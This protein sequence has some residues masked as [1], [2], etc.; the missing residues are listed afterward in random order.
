M[1]D[2]PAGSYPAAVVADGAVHYW[3][4]DEVEGSLVAVDN[5]GA[6]NGNISG[7]VTLGVPGALLSGNASMVFDGISGRIVTPNVINLRPPYTIEAWVRVFEQGGHAFFSTL[8]PDE[9]ED[10]IYV[11]TYDR[12]IHV[13]AEHHGG[14]T[15]TDS[16]SVTPITDGN[17]HYI[18]VIVRG[19]TWSLYVDGLFDLLNVQP[20]STID[21][22]DNYIAELGFTSKYGSF[23]LNGGL[24]EVAIYSKI[25]Q[26]K[27][28]T[29]HYNLRGYDPVTGIV[30][31]RHT[32]M[33]IPVG[34]LT[35][36]EQNASYATP[37]H[38]CE[39]TSLDPIEVA[40]FRDGPYA[41]YNGA[42]ISRS[43]LRSPTADT[44]V[45]CKPYRTTHA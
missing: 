26:P 15:K 25:L 33:L 8:Q 41:V 14:S 7:G 24:D 9:S 11:G 20:K 28:I 2:F 36:I 32:N 45:T 19:Q 29:E 12:K 13:R 39:I 31:A 3:R 30:Q 42:P 23:E 5:I 22:S 44:L 4:L 27:Q 34:P 6:L 35:P 16:I 1:A 18:V 43:F 21:G 38:L 40:T 17:W 10:G 37:A